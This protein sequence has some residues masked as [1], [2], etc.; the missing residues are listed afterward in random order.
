MKKKHSLSTS[1]LVA[2][3]FHQVAWPSG[4][5]PEIRT[6]GVLHNQWRG[7]RGERGVGG[8][9][10]NTHVITDNS[11]RAHIKAARGLSPV[12]QA[13]T[14]W[15]PWIP[16]L[17]RVVIVG[18]GRCRCGRCFLFSPSPLLFIFIFFC[19]TLSTL[20]AQVWV[21]SKTRPPIPATGTRAAPSSSPEPSSPPSVRI[22]Q[23][24]AHWFVTGVL[25]LSVPAV[26]CEPLFIKSAPAHCKGAR[27]LKNKSCCSFT[28]EGIK[29]GCLSKFA[30]WCQTAEGFRLWSI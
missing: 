24:S 14:P 9:L 30:C 19:S 12:S 15:W 22:W 10:S 13:G 16:L 28:L 8:G 18:G 29:Q 5:D 26:S 17:M 27:W 3:C 20:W 25:K 11:W 23:D 4:V 7:V 2:P 21:L 1:A 6:A